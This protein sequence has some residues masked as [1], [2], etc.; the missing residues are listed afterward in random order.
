MAVL[1]CISQESSDSCNI[2]MLPRIIGF[3]NGNAYDKLRDKV[4]SFGKKM[5]L[6][7]GDSTT[8]RRRINT[9]LQ[10]PLHLIA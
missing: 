6:I 5:R 1:F 4:I 3:R 2:L 7:G 8:C 10:E 9:E